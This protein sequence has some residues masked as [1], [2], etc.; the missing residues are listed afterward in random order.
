MK[1]L[2][3]ATTLALV[4]AANVSAFTSHPASLLQRTSS[5]SP[6]ILHASSNTE[7][8]TVTV[9]LPGDGLQANMKFPPILDV[10]S[11]IVEVR[12]AVPFGLDVAPKDGL[13]VCTKDGV[14]VSADVLCVYYVV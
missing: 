1:G 11:E 2:S 5:S 10:P 14:S 13:A 3:T 12:Y 6:S 4:I 9:N 8:F 7:P